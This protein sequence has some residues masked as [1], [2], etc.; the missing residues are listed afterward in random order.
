MDHPNE[1]TYTQ[2]CPS[3]RNRLGL[4]VVKETRDFSFAAQSAGGA[5]AL[6]TDWLNISLVEDVLSYDVLF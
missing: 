4:G 1:M 2:S 3:N 5:A 6:V